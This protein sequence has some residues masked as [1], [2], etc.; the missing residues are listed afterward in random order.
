M[1]EKPADLMSIKL[2]ED[3]VKAKLQ[4]QGINFILKT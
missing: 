2:D 4:N 3:K 1:N